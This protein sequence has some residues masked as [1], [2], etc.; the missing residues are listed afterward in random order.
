[1]IGNRFKL[2]VVMP[3]FLL[4]FPALASIG[5]EIKADRECYALYEHIHITLKIRNNSGNR[6]SFGEMS[7]GRRR[8]NLHFII[9]D[10][11][12]NRIQQRK[13]PS[14]LIS[15]LV[16]KAGATKEITFPLNNFFNLARESTYT[17]HAQI[18]HDRLSHAYRTS[19]VR[20]EVREPH[21]VWRQN[22]GL[23]T[24][25]EDNEIKHRTA[26]IRRLRHGR[27]EIY[28]FQ[29]EDENY[30][31]VVNRIGRH[32]SGANPQGL[33][34]GNG[35]T[36]VLL[37]IKSRIFRY[38]LYNYK[39]DF[40]RERYYTFANESRPAL[41][42]DGKT[43]AVSVVGGRRAEQGQDYVLPGDTKDGVRPPSAPLLEPL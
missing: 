14:E 19:G 6:L 11:R 16:L 15:N 3:L 39:G 33:V 22:F 2:T 8:G 21:P 27:K 10:G 23:P 35:N 1:M 5:I 32:I 40:L 34:D 4:S 28:C 42:R 31:Y 29:I 30:V 25:D 26:S 17:V 37:R 36:H 41:R 18:G 13:D 12:G 20:V 9:Q 38:Q 43:G 24:E 7:E